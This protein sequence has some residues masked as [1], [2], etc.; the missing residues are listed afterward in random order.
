[1]AQLYPTTPESYILPVVDFDNVDFKIVDNTGVKN[2]RLAQDEVIAYLANA[3]P[4][5]IAELSAAGRV[6][7]K[8]LERFADNYDPERYAKD[9]DYLTTDLIN[10]VMSLPALVQWAAALEQAVPVWLPRCRDTEAFYVNLSTAEGECLVSTLKQ[11]RAALLLPKL[12]L[13]IEVTEEDEGDWTFSV[14]QRYGRY[15][16]DVFCS[17]ANFIEQDELLAGFVYYR[18][19]SVI[20]P[21]LAVWLEDEVEEPCLQGAWLD[22]RDALVEAKLQLTQLRPLEESV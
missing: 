8:E 13:N 14:S 20:I 2:I 5:E 15:S 7:V 21:K 16:T 18:H 10:T 22:L 1:M 9:S 12:D 3:S 19:L 6:D 4:D 11:C 17:A